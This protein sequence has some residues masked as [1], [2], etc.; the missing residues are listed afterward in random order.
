MS[1]IFTTFAVA[2][3]L[4]TG[5]TQTEIGCKGTTKNPNMQIKTL[6]NRQTYFVLLLALLISGATQAKVSNYIGATAQVADWTL[7]PAKSQYGSSFGPVGGVGF[8][9]EMQAGKKY[10]PTRFLFDLGVGAWGGMTAFSQGSNKVVSLDGQRDLQGD[11]FS[12]VYEIKNRNDYYTNIAVQV[13]VL[14]GFQH[15]AFYMLVGMKFDASVFTRA[16]S[17][18]TLTT[19]G[20]YPDFGIIG[21]S[22]EL[23]QYHLFANEKKHNNAP[24][25]L[26]LNVAL[27]LEL[28]GRIGVLT[29]D[30]VYDVPKRNVE[31]RFAGFIDYGLT[32]VHTSRTLDA[33]VTPTT[34]N[35]NPESPDYVYNT[36][37]M[38][39]GVELND[40]M[41]TKNF[42]SKVNNLMIGVKF[43]IL[44]QLPETGRCLLCYD[45]YKSL[46]RP[47][48]GRSGM[49]YEE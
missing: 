47:R 3:D 48:G 15:K 40:L 31:Y 46:V 33:I 1:I 39:D 35:T 41:S 44:F 17:K 19:Y 12:Y 2:K 34:Y 32:D 38:I 26:K 11:P 10:S 6:K 42:A 36:R 25:S 16:H 24:A 27:S 21:L 9:Y 45:A 7:M 8:V 23:P 20:N 22:P 43:T 13:P 18:A 49:K 4:R 5:S 29:S 30:L 28:G 37:T 14:L